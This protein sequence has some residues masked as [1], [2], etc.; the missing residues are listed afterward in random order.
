MERRVSLPSFDQIA[1]ALP[2]PVPP[3]HR[4]I[5]YEPPPPPPPLP[6]QGL[7]YSPALDG[8]RAYRPAGPYFALD[9]QHGHGHTSSYSLPQQHHLR[10]ASASMPPPPPTA[11]PYDRLQAPKVLYGAR[12][13]LISISHSPSN[14]VHAGARSAAADPM[15]QHGEAASPSTL[16][17]QSI[18]HHAPARSPA[19]IPIAQYHFRAA[20][21]P[22]HEPAMPRLACDMDEDDD[23]DGDDNDSIADNDDARGP[24]D[25]AAAATADGVVSSAKLRTIHKLAERRRRRE[26]KALFDALRRCLP[27]DKTIRVSKWETL[28]KAIEVISGQ[29]TEI[30]MLR[31]HLDS[32]KALPTGNTLP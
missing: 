2:R 14:N 21:F 8:S 32:A 5:P 12:G 4:S 7:V 6:H 22:A 16:T 24:L 30:R 28:K 25:K 20:P 31:M 15:Q 27:I 17:Q 13:G 3:T 9:T 10:L 11:K 19:D 26:M 1:G 18:P 29:E 23:N